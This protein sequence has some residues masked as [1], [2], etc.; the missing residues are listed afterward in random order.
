M[1]VTQVSEREP[2]SPKGIPAAR[3][4]A[5]RLL[6]QLHTPLILPLVVPRLDTLLQEAACRR[7]LDW[8]CYHTLPLLFDKARGGYRASQLIFGV[9]P[10]AGL[11]AQPQAKIGHIQRLPLLQAR[12]VR[13]ALR[14]D[15]GDWAPKMTHH[16]A[17]LSPY[18][19]F[20]AEG[21]PDACI[22][23]LQELPQ[24]GIGHNHGQGMISVASVSPSTEQRWRQR[25]WRQAE[26]HTGMAY[27]PLTDTLRMAPW[28][29]DEPVFRPPR[30]LREI[31][32]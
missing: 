24:I 18:V 4:Q 15:G 12:N 2:P 31:L 6:L 23:L 19:L 11:E 1:E 7:A 25:P 30:I 5:F 26:E 29:T 32:A 16:Q 20:Y 21:D 17:L 9:T 27:S 10:H 22:N 8:S 28:G 3:A 14:I 13:A